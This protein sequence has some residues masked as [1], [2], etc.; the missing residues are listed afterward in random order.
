MCGA[1]RKAGRKKRS[2]GLG[3]DGGG[4]NSPKRVEVAQALNR[5]LFAAMCT[6]ST[7]HS[8]ICL[9]KSLSFVFSCHIVRQVKYF[10][11]FVVF[12]S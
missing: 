4:W 10:V 6:Y 2:R 5:N 12:E 9:S 1:S 11:V 8:A 7:Q 3:N